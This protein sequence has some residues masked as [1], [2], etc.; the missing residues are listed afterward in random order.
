MV[1][2]GVDPGIGCPDAG[3]DV[4]RVVVKPH[5]L[6]L[7]GCGG[8]PLRDNKLSF[9]LKLESAYYRDV[10]QGLDRVGAVGPAV[11]VD[12]VLV[13]ASAATLDGLPE[14][15]FTGQ[16]SREENEERKCGLLRKLD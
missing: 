7:L 3:V 4:A 11:G 1:V 16:H 5:V 6:L 15:L 12:D 13:D 8:P 2:P 14:I 9:K 10:L